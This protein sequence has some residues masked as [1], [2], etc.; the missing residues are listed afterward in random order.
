MRK[1]QEH[2]EQMRIQQDQQRLDM[3]AFQKALLEAAQKETKVEK[4]NKMSP[5]GQARATEKI[6]SKTKVVE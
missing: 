1:Q 2:Q 5:L 6:S 4:K 3:L